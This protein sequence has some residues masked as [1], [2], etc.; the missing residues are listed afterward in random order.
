MQSGQSESYSRLI[1][2]GLLPLPSEDGGD[3]VANNRSCCPCCP[4]GNCCAPAR[5]ARGSAAVVAGRARGVLWCA[6]VCG[7]VDMYVYVC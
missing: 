3:A 5:V 6:R 1:C 2:H 4:C 7:G